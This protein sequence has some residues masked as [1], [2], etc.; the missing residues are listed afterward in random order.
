MKNVITLKNGSPEHDPSDPWVLLEAGA[1][2]MRSDTPLI[3][4]FAHWLEH[5]QARAPDPRQGVLLGPDEDPLRLVPAVSHLPLIALQFPDF[6]DGRAY[7]QANLLRLRYGFRGDLRAVGDVLRDQLLL[8]RH[9]GFSS[10][11]IRE[12]KP[13]LDALEGLRGFDEVYARSV[14]NPVPRYRR[15]SLKLNPDRVSGT[16]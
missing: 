14:A 5:S 2:V 15:E 12:D 11:A 3:L 4:P 7:S 6:R 13:V 8:M 9:C 1:D 10:F 16:D